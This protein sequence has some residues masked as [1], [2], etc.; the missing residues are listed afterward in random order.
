MTNKMN[1]FWQGLVVI[2]IGL[3]C[4]GVAIYGQHY[5]QQKNWDRFA[6][7]YYA[8]VQDNGD[9]HKVRLTIPH[10]HRV[11]TLKIVDNTTGMSTHV[12]KVN[13]LKINQHRGTMKAIGYPGI[14]ADHYRHIGSTIKLT[15][16]GQTQTYYRQG[17]PQQ[18]KYEEHFQH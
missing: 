14:P 11:A 7:T 3:V 13:R 10:D 5:R 6:G 4:I 12:T 9:T 16:A 2:V 8:Y 17:T 18:E 15:T 1:G